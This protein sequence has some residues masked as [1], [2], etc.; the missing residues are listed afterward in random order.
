MFGLAPR[1]GLRRFSSA[2]QQIEKDGARILRIVKKR[3]DERA[4]IASQVRPRPIDILSTTYA[5]SPDFRVHVQPGGCIM[6]QTAEGDGTHPRGMGPMGFN[7]RG[8]FC[9]ATIHE[10]LRLMLML[11]S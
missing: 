8:V 10:H 9:Y 4:S 3:V 6:S 1:L 7:T 5:S 2:I 11:S